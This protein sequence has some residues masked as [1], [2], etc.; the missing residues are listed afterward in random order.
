MLAAYSTDRDRALRKFETP[1]EAM[2]AAG[3]R[4]PA[5]SR[6]HTNMS[7]LLTAIGFH[8]EPNA[9]SIYEDIDLTAATTNVGERQTNA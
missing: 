6:L 4:A 2:S 5:N 3:A 7:V 9:D 8:H 1:V